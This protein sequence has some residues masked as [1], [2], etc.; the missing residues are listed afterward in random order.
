MQIILNCKIWEIERASTI[1]ANQYQLQKERDRLLDVIRSQYQ[2]GGSM[3]DSV[4]WSVL[5]EMA[6]AFAAALAAVPSIAEENS[7]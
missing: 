1:F 2:S 3:L 7:K 4:E 5:A 6:G